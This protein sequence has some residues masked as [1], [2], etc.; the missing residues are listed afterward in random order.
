MADKKPNVIVVLTDDQGYGDLSCH[1]NPLLKTPNLDRLHSESVRLTDFH[2]A[3]M[4]TPTRSQLLSGRDCLANGACFVDGGRAYMRTE[5]PTMAD[6]FVRNGYRTGHFGK[7]HLG[8]HYPY[9]P[10]ERGF[11]ESI[12]HKAWGIS[13]VPDYWNNDYYD[14]HYEHNG[15]MEQYSGYCTDVW[16]GEAMDWM[17]E[18][19]EA[20]EP[21]LA[22][23]ATNAAHSPWFVGDEFREDYGSEGMALASFFGMIACIDHNMGRLE[24]MLSETGL[25]DNTILIYMTDNGGTMGVPFYNAG[26]RGRKTSLY[27]GGHRVPC[28]IRWP[29]GGL[30]RPGDVDTPTQV[31]DV[32]PTLLDLCG[33]ETPEDVRFDGTSLTGL[34]KGGELDERMFVVQYGCH[35]KEPFEVEWFGDPHKWAGTVV[36]GN[37]RLVRGEELYNTAHD[38][39]Q[40]EDVAANNPEV[41]GQMR[42]FYEDWWAELEPDVFDFSYIPVGAEEE[43]EVCLT[44]HV[45]LT[46][47]VTLTYERSEQGNVRMGPHRNGPWNIR[48]ERSGT[49]R[50]SLR[51][52]PKEAGAAVRDGVPEYEPQDAT[53]HPFVEG[54]A[55]PIA[56]AHIQVAQVEASLPVEQEQKSVEFEVELPAGETRLQ[57]WFLDES[58]EEICGAYYAYV[59]RL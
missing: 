39:G 18:R 40:Q 27:E 25:R 35:P 29:A 33:L 26:M 17:G 54:V 32:L 51:R 19:A 50:I 7:W 55:L 3:P 43:P 42:A 52:W 5:L 8:D 53:F 4:C 31:Q 14:D 48:V 23:I 2:V 36:W 41:V 28:F 47:P 49:Y 34:L 1:G 46:T 16:F 37:W 10:Q 44:S 58:G 38:P 59:T 56:E 30:R 57:S 11:E 22:Y 45:W 9:R 21:F 12:F 6:I 13:S 24:E 20:D 15:T